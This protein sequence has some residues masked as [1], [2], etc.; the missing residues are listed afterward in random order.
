MGIN[1]ISV[2]EF[3]HVKH[4]TLIPISCRKKLKQIIQHD[5]G[6]PLTLLSAL[7]ALPSCPFTFLCDKCQHEEC[8]SSRLSTSWH[9]WIRS[10]VSKKYQRTGDQ[11]KT[12]PENHAKRYLKHHDSQYLDPSA[13]LQYVSPRSLLLYFN[14]CHK[15][16]FNGN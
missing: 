13:K 7:F 9:M 12:R 1:S 11:H 2:L 14:R 16:Q 3:I 8:F 10:R 5:S 6:C 4:R 15:E